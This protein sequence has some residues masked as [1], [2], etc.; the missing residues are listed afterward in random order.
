LILAATA[1]AAALLAWGWWHAHTHASV[2]V[3][4]NDVALKTPQRRWA[5]LTAGELALHDRSAH[6]LAR[7]RVR[8]PL[9]IVDFT[10]AA[11]GNCERFEG[12]TPHDNA[13]HTGWATCFEGRS[14]WQAGWVREVATATVTTAACRIDGVPVRS[15]VDNDWWLWWVPLPHVGGTPYANYSFEILIDSANCV[16][17]SPDP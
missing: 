15:R 12:G 10:D 4:V 13:Q 9:G 17:V 8:E 2:H 11:A 16:A 5:G 1:L 6:A 3:A 7:G 14:R